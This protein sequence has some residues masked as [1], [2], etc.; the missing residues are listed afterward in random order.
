MNISRAALRPHIAILTTSG[1][2]EARP[3]VGYY[4]AGKE[5]QH[6]CAEYFEKIKVEDIKSVPVVVRE[7][8]SIYDAAVT[9][10]LEETNALLVVDEEGSLKGLASQKDLLKASLGDSNLHQMPVAVIMTRGAGLVTLQPE[11]NVLEAAVKMFEFELDALP[12]VKEEANN[13][14]RVTGCVNKSLLIRLL[15]E[16]KRST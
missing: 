12:V 6:F 11:E 14:L 9:L 2:L 8:T 16:V 3:R 15:T 1:L 10:F 4:Y 5:N 7:Q 13:K